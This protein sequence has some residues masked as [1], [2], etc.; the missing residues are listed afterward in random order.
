MV[1][2]LEEALALVSASSGVAFAMSHP[3]PSPQWY[4][5]LV[6]NPRM[7]IPLRGEKRIVGSFDGEVQ[8]RT[9]HPGDVLFC[10]PSGWSCERWNSDHEM[11]SLTFFDELLRAIYIKHD[12]VSAPPP[13]PSV[14]YHAAKPIAE[15][16]RHLLKALALASA[17]PDR[18]EDA[19]ALCRAL[20]QLTARALRDDRRGAGGKA[21]FLWTCVTKYLQENWAAELSRESVAAN[22]RIHPNHLSRLFKQH[23]GVSFNDYV[24]GLKM[25]RATEALES[26]H[27]TID[28]IA[29]H[30]GYKYTSYFIRVFKKHHEMPP[31][32]YRQSRTGPAREAT[33][34]R[35]A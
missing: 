10:V 33:K 4:C 20:L 11:I 29:Q 30:C 23:A 24:T 31:A 6:P 22:F 35:D 16:G 12:G 18:L 1:E 5:C 27:Y 34:P 17:A 8:E 28:E 19:W 13:G 9:F 21:R 7:I 32:A 15:A 3:R 25:E 2:H 14:F 26:G